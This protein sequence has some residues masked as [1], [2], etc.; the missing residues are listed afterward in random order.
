MIAARKKAAVEVYNLE[1]SSKHGI[2]FLTGKAFARYIELSPSTFKLPGS[3]PIKEVVKVLR[4]P[5]MVRESSLGEGIGLEVFGLEDID[6][7]I[8]F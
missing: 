1:V 2:S 6:I 7:L 5:W 3:I 4:R 8:P